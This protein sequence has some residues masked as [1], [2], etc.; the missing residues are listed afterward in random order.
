MKYQLFGNTGLRISELSLGTMTFGN[1]WGWG[2]DKVTSAKIFDLYTAAGGNFID[3]ANLYSNGKSEK[4]IG[5]FIKS[6]RSHFVLGTK[7]TLKDTFSNPPIDP[8]KSGMHKK[9]MMRSVEESLKRLK[10]DYLDILWVHAWDEFS[11]GDLLMKNL[12]Q[13]INSGKVLHI[14]ISDA[15]AWRVARANTIAELRGWNAFAGLQI[16]YSL[17]QRS[18]ERDLLP[19]ADEFGLTITPW[20]PL[21]GGILTGK[22]LKKGTK[23]RANQGNRLT[24]KR[25]AI[26]KV[27]VDIAKEIDQEPAQVAI[28]WLMKQHQ[29][30][31]PIIGART[32]KQ[33]KSNLG[34]L[35]MDLESKHLEALDQVSQIELGFPHEFLRSDNV[36]SIIYSDAYD[37]IKR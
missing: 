11:D 24:E 31:V 20:S 29:R 27:V 10:T 15:P 14:A 19:M 28:R 7:F 9:N 33:M 17:I 36:K 6:D 2:A 3:T 37:Q 21:G 4:Y 26:A 34:V 32:P 5:E 8:N 12:E 13:L 22:F 18:A 16:E 23:G 30:I 25:Q 1:D 35:N